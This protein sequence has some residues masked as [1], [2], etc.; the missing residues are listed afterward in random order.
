MVSDLKKHF[1]EI[2]ISSFRMIH[3]VMD[4]LL[5]RLKNLKQNINA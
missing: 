4:I 1:V 5:K 3:Q 2:N